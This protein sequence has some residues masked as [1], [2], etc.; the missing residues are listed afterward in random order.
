M[1]SNY[2][3]LA[4]QCFS[5]VCTISSNEKQKFEK[6]GEFAK[7]MSWLGSD[8]EDKCSLLGSFSLP[9]IVPHQGGHHE[10]FHFMLTILKNC[11]HTYCKHQYDLTN[12]NCD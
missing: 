12:H 1:K 9:P 3:F 8:V 5:M 7:D 10:H 2:I 4:R 11:H 6:A